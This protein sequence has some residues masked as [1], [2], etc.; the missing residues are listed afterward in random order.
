MGNSNLLTLIHILLYIALLDRIIQCV[1]NLN[2]ESTAFEET[3]LENEVTIPSFTLCKFPFGNPPS[4]QSFEDAN[5][6]I[7]TSKSQYQ[8][9]IE[10]F[11]PY[12]ET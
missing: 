2:N 1:H 6:E 3:E 5:K 4:I 9:N 12:K 8:S 7:R 10:I 11:K